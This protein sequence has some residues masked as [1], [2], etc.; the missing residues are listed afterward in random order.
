MYHCYSI[1]YKSITIIIIIFIININ[2]LWTDVELFL[3]VSMDTKTEMFKKI[4]KVKL[5]DVKEM[6]PASHCFHY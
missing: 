6:T 2:N 5:A 3:D 1:C 4:N